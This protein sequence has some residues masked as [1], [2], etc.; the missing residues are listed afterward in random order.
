MR[1]YKVTIPDDKI[2]FFVKLMENLGISSELDTNQISKTSKLSASKRTSRSDLTTAKEGKIGN[3]KSKMASI[4]G[5]KSI[6][7]VLGKI[8]ELRNKR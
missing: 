2:D 8:Q 4:K 1:T 5:D 7:D 6:Q 3:M